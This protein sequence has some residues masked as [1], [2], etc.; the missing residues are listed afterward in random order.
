M[1]NPSL[2]TESEL[3]Y[4]CL[5]SEHFSFICLTMKQLELFMYFAGYLAV[6]LFLN[7]SHELLLLLVNTVLKVSVGF[8]QHFFILSHLLWE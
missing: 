1:H 4:S 6:S 5:L 7:E 8:L 2:P 3:I